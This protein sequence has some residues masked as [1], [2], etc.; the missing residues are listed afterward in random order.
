MAEFD[1]EV[2]Q[3][4]LKELQAARKQAEAN[5][6]EAATYGDKD[7]GYLATQEMNNC[8]RA[9]QELVNIHQRTRPQ[10]PQYRK[11]QSI[12]DNNKDPRDFTIED[13]LE[14]YNHNTRRDKITAQDL[15]N[16]WDQEAWDRRPGQGGKQ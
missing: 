13:R 11:R 1:D 8:D 9:A 16:A 3:Q 12:M 5:Y 2:L 4:G 6:A 7:A 10:Q 14:I 15:A